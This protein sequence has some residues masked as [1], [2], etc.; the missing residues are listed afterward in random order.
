MRLVGRAEVPDTGQPVF[1]VL[2]FGAASTITDPFTIG[3]VT[4]LPPEGGPP[5]AERSIILSDGQYPGI[6][7]G[8]QP[9]DG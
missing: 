2:L 1:E 5:R 6:L 4:H 9:L 8:W 3:T 7:P